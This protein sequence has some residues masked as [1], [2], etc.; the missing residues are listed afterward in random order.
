MFDFFS[1]KKEPA[2]SPPRKEYVVAQ[3]D[4]LQDGQMKEVSVGETGKKILLTRVHGKYHA[5]SHLCTHFKAPLI[6]GKFEMLGKCLG[7]ACVSYHL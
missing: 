2:N 5:T 4:D 3:K 1:R 7:N 6:K